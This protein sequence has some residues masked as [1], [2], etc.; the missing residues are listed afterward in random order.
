MYFPLPPE[1]IDAINTAVHAYSQDCFNFCMFD[2]PPDKRQT[3]PVVNGRGKARNTQGKH[4][5]WYHW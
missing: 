2:L 3:T 4:N 1:S 5:Q